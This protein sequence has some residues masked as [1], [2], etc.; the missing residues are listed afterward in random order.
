MPTRPKY[1]LGINTKII[2][3]VFSTCIYFDFVIKLLILKLQ[4]RQDF[5][6][7]CFQILLIRLSRSLIQAARKQ[8]I[9][10]LTLAEYTLLEYKTGVGVTRF[11]G[12][13]FI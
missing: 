4:C 5:Y 8:H 2:E 11:H 9:V 3:A 13:F 1:I 7:R 10:T 12:I 6:F